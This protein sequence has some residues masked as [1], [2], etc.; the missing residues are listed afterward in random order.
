MLAASAETQSDGRN[1]GGV[2]T[3]F[4]QSRGNESRAHSIESYTFLSTGRILRH[5]ATMP[6]ISISY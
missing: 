5:I 3:A 4:N 1:W 6:V 2:F